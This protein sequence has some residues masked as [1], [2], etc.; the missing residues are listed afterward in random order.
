MKTVQIPVSPLLFYINIADN[1]IITTS[2]FELFIL[3]REDAAFA[4][5]KASSLN[6]Y[7]YVVLFWRHSQWK[8]L[9]VCSFILEDFQKYCIDVSLVSEHAQCFLPASMVISNISTGS[10]TILHMNRCVCVSVSLTASVS[11]SSSRSRT[12]TPTSQSSG[13]CL[14]FILEGTWCFLSVFLSVS[15]WLTSRSGPSMHQR[16]FG[17]S[18]VKLRVLV[19]WFVRRPELEPSFSLIRKTSDVD[20]QVH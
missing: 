6:S 3:T 19:V 4:F 5:Q 15:S 14:S 7:L 16:W 11:G 9:P 8:Q 20:E 1:R 17:K 12:T 2:D 18:K 13:F 10:R